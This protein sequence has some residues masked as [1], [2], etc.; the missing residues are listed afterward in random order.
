ME[1]SIKC[2]KPA[3]LFILLRQF[4]STYSVPSIEIVFLKG[5]TD[6]GESD[7]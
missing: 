1:E 7:K 6:E 2:E 3:G 4:L 5:L